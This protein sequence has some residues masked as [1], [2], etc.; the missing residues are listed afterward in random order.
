MKRTLALCSLIIM[1]G[2]VIFVSEGKGEKEMVA[3]GKKVRFDYVLT[4][5]GK[6]V[7]SSE[8]SGPYEYVHGEGK[9]VPGLERQ[10][11]GL[12]V[13]GKKTIAVSAEEGFGQVDPN[14][15]R[16]VSKSQFPPDLPLEV[17]KVLNMR[18]PDGNTLPATVLEVMEN[19]VML[20]FNH[21]LAGKNL[22]FDVTV[23]AIQ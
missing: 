14:A 11:E 5:D 16:E 17:G 7:D 4:V 18:T 9:I 3:A 12:E 22:Q 20:D 21:P 23:V 2:L 19:A 15:F 10:M 1:M 8:T 13:G 6:E